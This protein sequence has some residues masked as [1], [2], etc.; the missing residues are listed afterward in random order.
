MG[1]DSHG[2]QPEGNIKID[3]GAKYSYKITVPQNQQPP[4]SNPPQ[5]TPNVGPDG[6]STLSKKACRVDKVH[7][8][9]TFQRKIGSDTIAGLCKNPLK[10]DKNGCIQTLHQP[11]YIGNGDG[12]IFA[13]AWFTDDRQ[14][15]CQAL[16]FNVQ[17]NSY[18]YKDSFEAMCRWALQ[19][20]MDDCK[21]TL[22]R[23]HHAYNEIDPLCRRYK[24]TRS[25]E[26]G[27]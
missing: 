10:A 9:P 20:A 19:S 22:A 23:K 4:A 16:P 15:P 17:D 26:R 3:C 2:M 7:D 18:T 11:E 5:P 12:M 1:V 6:H 27:F 13:Q 24:H 25:E 14:G 21:C 8:S